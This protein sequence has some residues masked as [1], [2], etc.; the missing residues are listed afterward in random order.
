[1]FLEL[2]SE[3]AKLDLC[4][5]ARVCPSIDLTN[6]LKRRSI[7]LVCRNVSYRNWLNQQ[8]PKDIYVWAGRPGFDL[9]Y[10]Q[11]LSCPIASRPTLDP[12]QP[13]I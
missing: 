5:T 7:Q 1:M 6:Q 2:E 12:T 3:L 8:P 10:G 13:A 11:R 4:L 9:R